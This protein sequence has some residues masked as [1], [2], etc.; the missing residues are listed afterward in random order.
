MTKMEAALHYAAK[1]WA[2]F[3]LTPNTKIPYEGSH[4]FKDATTNDR[5]ITNWWT[6]SPTS[7]IGIATGKTFV[8]LDVDPRHGGDNSLNALEQQYGALPETPMSLTGGGGVHYLFACPD[9]R[10]IRC[11]A[12]T[13]G[14]G[15]DVKVEGGYI[16]VPPSIHPN[17][18]V[19]E[20]DAAHHP[21]DMPLAPVP[22]W[23][24]YKLTAQP[25]RTD[26]PKDGERIPVGQR[27]EALT[28]EAGRLRRIGLSETELEA[29]LLAIN[30]ERCLPPLSDDEVHDIAA[31]VARY[32][33]GEDH[34]KAQ[35]DHGPIKELA[36]EILA[37]EHF[38]RDAGG[39]LYVF[40]DGA[41]RPHGE[42]SISQHVK[43]ILLANGGT[44]QWSSHRARE[45]QEYIRVDAPLLWERPPVD[46]LNLRNGLLNLSTGTLR[47]HAPEYL[48]PVQLPVA[49]EPTALCPLWDSFIARVLPDDCRRLPYELVTASLRG[50]VSDQQAVLLVGA[51]ENGKSTLLAAI[52]A[53]LGRENVSSLALQR[54]ELDKFSV[55][56]LLGKLANICADLSSDHL[57]NTSTFK[58]LTGGDPLTAERKFQGSFEFVSFARLL[59]STNHYPQ[60][61]DSSQAFFRRW[62]VIPFDAVIDPH[63]R[64]P[65]L[66]VRLAEPHELSGVLNLALSLLPAMTTRGGFSQSETTRAAMMEFREMT[67][68]LAAWVE[69]A[70]DT[71]PHGITSKKDLHIAYGA[72]ADANGRPPMSPKSF[73]AGVKRLRPG[74]TEAQRRIHGEIR[75]VFLGIALKGQNGGTVSALSAH[76]AHSSQISL[77]CTEKEKERA[78]G[79]SRRNELNGLTPL[80]GGREP[81]FAC[82]GTQFWQ[83]I[84]GAV[85]CGECH[86]P[87]SPSLVAEWINGLPH[88]PGGKRP[89]TGKQS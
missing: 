77:G 7:N 46:T 43:A 22:P 42:V 66:A 11:S 14:P 27:N 51:G 16:V 10:E 54:L 33:K 1:G 4:G 52:V 81:C 49:Y 2:V 19:Y 25:D 6:Q 64:I 39:Q 18:T 37:S 68:P 56:R 12:G 72:H 36:D 13:L 71:T 83:S 44:K 84:H 28:R 17:G 15:L 61:K 89:V 70:T 75:D 29:T 50:E 32:P 5:C 82:R 85:T 63:E 76:S 59:F 23:L 31:S 30:R 9:T 69:R 26:A 3:P 73:Y 21:D 88:G 78:I 38:A 24:L 65:N 74:L 48:S 60:S 79:L 62:L 41:Y 80:T 45:V 47:P 53:F 67:D 55:V 8:V 34:G 86:P 87:S 57:A 35:S 20:W 40:T 58:A